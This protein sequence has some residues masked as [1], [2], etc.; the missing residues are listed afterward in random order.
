LIAANAAG[1]AVRKARRIR[2]TAQA[3]DSAFDHDQRDNCLQG[4]LKLTFDGC[5]S[6]GPPPPTFLPRRETMNKRIFAALAAMVL[7]LTLAACGDKAKEAA[8]AAKASADKAAAAAKEAAG[9]AADAAKAA[10]SDAATA[11]KEAADKA[12]DATKDAAMKATDAT[13]DAAGKA[14]EAAK[15]AAKPAEAPKK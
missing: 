7:A 1:M 9:K 2:A 10:A 8:D 13:K 4:A 3:N 14:V 15:E 5:G 12:A 6:E 11:T